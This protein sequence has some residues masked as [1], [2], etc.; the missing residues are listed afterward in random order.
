[1]GFLD[2]LKK[3]T[4]PYDDD[5]DF[6]EGAS[7]SEQSSAAAVSAAQQQFENVFGEE[8]V[9]AAEPAERKSAPKNPEGGGLFG[10]FGARRAEKKPRAPLR[11]RT[12]N[13]GGSDTQVILFN[14]KTFDEAGE[15][16]GHLLR[17]RSVVMTLEGLP[18]ENARRLL[19]FMSG[20]AFALQGKITPI[21]AKT[22]FV[23]PQNVDSLGAQSETAE[24]GG[25]YF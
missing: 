8:S 25:D 18:T 16:V 5:D 10:G 17:S 2:E 12:V 9:S 11:E 3:L 19:D 15:L 13:F 23:T 21:S 6:F 24:S 14:P 22:Y 1:M 7:E 4:Q 20:I